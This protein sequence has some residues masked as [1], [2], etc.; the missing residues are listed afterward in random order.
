MDE[1]EEYDDDQ[2]ADD[3]VEFKLLTRFWRNERCAP[4]LFPY[5]ERLM[6]HTKEKGWAESHLS[7]IR[8]STKSA[9][10][11]WIALVK[12]NLVCGTVQ[13]QEDFIREQEQCLLREQKDR[14][15]NAAFES[16]Q[17]SREA[18]GR[19]EI[20][21]VMLRAM[22]LEVDRLNLWDSPALP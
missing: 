20:K 15:D 10:T 3:F 1:Y 22:S 19:L 16:D 8:S 7:S 18:A 21:G 13:D 5:Q 11:L 9:C 2:T 14:I 17:E 6:E 12:T 4:A